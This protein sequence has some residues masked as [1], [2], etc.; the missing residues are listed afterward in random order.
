MRNIQDRR[1]SVS[2]LLITADDAHIYTRRFLRQDTC[3]RASEPNLIQ[4][5]RQEVTKQYGSR[6]RV[7]VVQIFFQQ[8]VQLH[9]N[10][11]IQWIPSLPQIIAKCT[12]YTLKIFLSL[13]KRA[14]TPA[15]CHILRGFHNLCSTNKCVRASLYQQ[16]RIIY[17]LGIILHYWYHNICTPIVTFFLLKFYRNVWCQL[18]EDG[19]I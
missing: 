18:P 1:H 6:T 14:C 4:A 2:Y 11:S 12:L 13:E 9:V 7:P 10:C 8:W 15:I 19:V 3:G 16:C 17:V 5:N